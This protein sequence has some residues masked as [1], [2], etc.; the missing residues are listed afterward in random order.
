MHQQAEHI[1]QFSL[2]R[3]QG[4]T[5]VPL[6]K[7]IMADLDTPVTTYLKLADC[8]YTFLFES[9]QG[10]EQWGRYS[11]IGLAAKKVIR[12]CNGKIL[13]DAPGAAQQVVDAA[14]PLQWIQSF[15]AEFRVVQIPELP[16][17]C[18]GLVGY[19]GYE[20]VRFFEK[21]LAALGNKS[22][23]L[24]VPD[25]LLMQTEEFVVF[26]NLKGV[27]TLVV[28]ADLASDP[29]GENAF[30]RLDQISLQLKQPLHNQPLPINL[31][32]QYVEKGASLPLSQTSFRSNFTEQGYC[33]VV[34][35]IK[36]YIL[37]G[38]VMQVLPSQRMSAPFQHPPLS[39]YRTLRMIN[40]SPY[41]YLLNL[42][43]F[44]IVGSSPEILVRVDQGTVTLR[45]IAGTR[46][47][48]KTPTEDQALELELLND[49]KEI[50]EHV[51]LIDL[52]RNDVGR[53]AEYGSVRLTDKMVVERYSHVMHIV[54]N[55]EGKLR[56]GLSAFDVLKAAFPAGT[57][58]G[59]PKIRAMEILSD[60]EPVKRGVYGGAVGYL[61]FQG[62]LDTAIAIRTAV[63]KEGE[64]HVQAGA[65]VVADSIP[66]LEW[67]ETLSKG[68]VLLNAA[69]LLDC[70]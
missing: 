35:K 68:Q 44:H 19:F 51:M 10:G 7:T 4:Y 48:G 22:D 38:D 29:L 32:S 40:P 9:V 33:E 12:V 6:I 57:L 67:Q 2:Y 5:H 66:H 26:D 27:M 45:P 1:S 49:P 24:S 16:R 15:M 18:G 69:S 65:G 34:E 59:A 53:V 62:D 17:F 23:P 37:S 14:D 64:I 36:Q 52:G 47:R 11:I 54:S 55:V 3:Q 50:A 70:Q 56:E 31:A 43:D 42:D 41:M 61:S 25:I 63:I 60:L 8:P 30:A 21:K 58:S 46:R 28:H 39:L 20:S 13:I